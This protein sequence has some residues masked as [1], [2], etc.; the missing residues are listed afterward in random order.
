MPCG[1]ERVKVPETAREMVTVI[2]K[3][4]R[5][6][7]KFKGWRAI[8]SPNVVGKLRE[9]LIAEDLHDVGELW[10]ER[11]CAGEGGNGFSHAYGSGEKGISELRCTRTGY[12]LRLQLD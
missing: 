4:G 5:D 11:A 3:P 10:H 2:P 9:K 1:Q 12:T 8:V 7:Q 6:H